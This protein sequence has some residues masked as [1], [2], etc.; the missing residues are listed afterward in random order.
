M[1][2]PD[3]VYQL[4]EQ[5]ILSTAR[6]LFLTG[7]AGTGKTT[8]LHRLKANST[9]Q[10]V[11]AAPT[12]VAAINAQGVTL[13]S[14]FQL[15][16][17]PY[18]PTPENERNLIRTIQMRSPRRRLLQAMEVLFIDEV[19]M[20]RADTLD[21]IDAVLRSVRRQPQQPF[22]GVQVVLMGDLFQ[23]SPVVKR[24]E[25]RL[26]E[27][28]YESPYFFSSRAFQ[29]L[30]WLYIEFDTIFRQ[31][32]ADFIDLLA[33]VREGRV[34]E[35]GLRLLNSRYNP[36]FKNTKADPHILLT[37]H[38]QLADQVNEQALARLKTP[39]RTYEAQVRG[40][41]PDASFP[42]D[43]TLTLKVGARVMFIHNDDQNPRRFYNGCMGDVVYLSDHSVLV[44]T[45]D[46][47]VEVPI[48]QWENVYYHTD[49]ETQTVLTDCKGTFE[50]YPLRLAWA[51]T[52]HKSQG[53]T[54]DKVAIDA[55]K[56]F[57]AGQVYVALSRCRTLEG[58]VLTSPIPSSAFA[59]DR[60]VL[61]FTQRVL[62]LEQL[63]AQL[64]PSQRQ[65]VLELLFCLFDFGKE[66]RTFADYADQVTPGKVF[67]VR[68]E[69]MHQVAD[70]MD[71]LQ[72]VA[73]RFKRELVSLPPERLDERLRA[74]STYFTQQLNEVLELW[75]PFVHTASQELAE[76]LDECLG[77]I[78]QAFVRKL[79]YL[80]TLQQGMR[81]DDYLAV[82][83]QPL[84]DWDKT[85]YAARP[86]KSKSFAQKKELPATDLVPPTSQRLKVVFPK[87][88]RL[89]AEL[90][91][92]RLEQAQSQGKPAFVVFSNKV[93]IA[94]V[95][96]CPQTK[97]E[98]LA[99]KGVGASLV[100]RYGEDLL[101]LFHRYA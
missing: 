4:A 56:A 84:P 72:Q 79:Q 93:L 2:Q 99:V 12:G 42:T 34:T 11:V 17:T 89:Q 92:Y 62:S 60:Q 50:Q 80:E 22:G 77:S 88:I 82:A 9:K 100:Q 26:M 3:T 6:C 35:Q 38:N 58:I 19:S 25:E 95:M 65:Y 1:P 45:E 43:A 37:T 46:D 48:M 36:Q 53:L 31:H 64:E 52:I 10:I 30:S 81:L 94:L 5:Y 70:Q 97:E 83:Q 51:I 63:Q 13:H 28:Y 74:A 29:R 69:P 39:C 44:K 16:F 40:D 27:A 91:A 15:P 101:Q 54:F 78:Y 21:A 7:K 33:Q 59:C 87:A 49:P 55:Q 86:K 32:D 67:D 47:T 90:R 41:F 57:A 71:R 61:S 23:L 75:Q 73:D 24:E 8:F 20:V 76:S 18:I 96:A 14:L 85:S 68:S 98:L 66:L